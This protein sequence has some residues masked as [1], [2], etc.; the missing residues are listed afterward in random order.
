[1][2]FDQL[3]AALREIAQGHGVTLYLV[4]GCVRDGLQ[5]RPLADLDVAVQGDALAY[6]RA[7]ASRL[8]GTYVP[9]GE[10]HHTARVVFAE[11]VVRQV[12]CAAIAGSIQEDLARRDFTINAMAAPLDAFRGD[13][14]LSPI[15]DPFG[16]HRDLAERV[17]RMVS[18]QSLEDD[19]LR[20]LRGVRLAA[21]LGFELEVDTWKAI[22]ERAPLL[23][24]CA[25]ERLREELCR[26]LEVERAVRWVE[27][28]DGLGLLAGLFPELLIGKGV[29]QPKEHYWDVF[30][31]EVETVAAI[32]ALLQPRLV[33]MLG[34]R[35]YLATVA[36]CAPSHPGLEAY[37]QESVGGLPRT[38]VLKLAAL[39]HD[40]AKPQ[41]KA[42]Q[43]DGRIRF[44]GHSEQGADMVRDA[45]GRLRFSTREIESVAAMVEYH[46]RPGQWS[47]VTP[48]SR[49][50]YRY[51]RD[52]GSVAVDTI[53]LNLADHLAAR[54]PKLNL[55]RWRQHV[56]VAQHAL[57]YY[58]ERRGETVTPR[59]VTGHDLMEAFG[60]APG[61]MLG[62]LL[63]E[64]E[65]ARVLEQ[66]VTKADALKLAK[67]ILEERETVASPSRRN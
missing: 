35:A 59:L 51:F 65:E 18:A 20:L 28:L 14:A 63:A 54:G 27:E 38:T 33:P 67:Q 11:G 37:L 7:V 46:L 47:G 16:G 8:G 15:I 2:T 32:E 30:N 53:L 49:A 26:I 61:P 60:L 58:F 23:T 36:Q 66:I 5:G 21:E 41:T 40:V 45:L 4:G 31:H 6:A 25:G 9:L 17:V 56:A 62:K 24:Q 34:D 1:M 12:D 42:V 52:V 3:L 22:Q 39:F 13:W 29:T 55:E 44:F 50:L 10:R 64:I 48:S 19:P 43:P 57:A